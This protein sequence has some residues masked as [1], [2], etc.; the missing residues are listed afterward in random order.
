MEHI[1]NATL[2]GGVAI[3][4]CADLMVQPW[5]ALLIGTI[6]GTISVYGF[7]EITVSSIYFLKLLKFFLYIC[8]M[9]TYIY[10]LHSL[11][12][13]NISKFMILVEFTISMEC[14]DSLEVSLVLSLLLPLP[15]KQL[16]EIR[17]L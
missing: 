8:S 14:L 5:A 15:L 11:P 12:S 7:D 6:A 17:K 9:H 1:Q 3:G 2:A 13:I 10:T 16:W 4:A